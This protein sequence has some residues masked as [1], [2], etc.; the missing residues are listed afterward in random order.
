MGQGGEEA[1]EGP[2][3]AARTRAVRQSVQTRARA[4]VSVMRRLPRLACPTGDAA[5]VYR[6]PWPRLSPQVTP[7]STDTTSMPSMRCGT[8]RASL[9]VT[10]PSAGAV[11]LVQPDDQRA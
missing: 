9:S 11:V 6:G 5:H 1:D 7:A 3:R 4:G 8:K 10:G 2:V